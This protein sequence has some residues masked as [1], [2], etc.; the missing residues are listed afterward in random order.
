[1][2]GIKPVPLEAVQDA[3]GR[4]NGDEQELTSIRRGFMRVT[5]SVP[6]GHEI[7]EKNSNFQTQV[8]LVSLELVLP[9]GDDILGTKIALIESFAVLRA[10]IEK[11]QSQNS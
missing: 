4:L 2:Q 10:E 5:G 1:M 6:P 11:S 9:E 3:L 8:A 7:I